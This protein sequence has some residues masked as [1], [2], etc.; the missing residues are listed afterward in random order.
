MP[1]SHN[2]GSLRP[3][4]EQLSAAAMDPNAIRQFQHELELHERHVSD[5]DLDS[6]VARGSIALGGAE[7]VRLL[8]RVATS[9]G[10]QVLVNGRRLELDPLSAQIVGVLHKCA[11]TTIEALC[12]RIAGFSAL[13]VR[14]ALLAL[15]ASDVVNIER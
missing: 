6:H 8:A 15:D 9:G 10:T 1:E 4:L 7:L 11:A 13:A 14:N 2:T 3:L 12:E 5:F